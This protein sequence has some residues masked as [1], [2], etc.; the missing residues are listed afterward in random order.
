MA[1]VIPDKAYT[2]LDSIHWCLSNSQSRSI[3]LSI[4]ED[5]MDAELSALQGVVITWVQFT[6]RFNEE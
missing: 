3:E 4:E 6:Y 2:R 1:Y 5:A